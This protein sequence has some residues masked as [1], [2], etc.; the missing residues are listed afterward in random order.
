LGS[1][2][3]TIEP[4]PRFAAKFQVPGFNCQVEAWTI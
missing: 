3:S 4:H 2:R 1:P